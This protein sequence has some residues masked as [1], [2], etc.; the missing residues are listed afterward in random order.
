MRAKIRTGET[1]EEAAARLHASKPHL[2]PSKRPDGRR[3]GMWAANVVNYADTRAGRRMAA[4][5][6]RGKR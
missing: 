1:R 4:A 3:I 5:V 2:K 6:A